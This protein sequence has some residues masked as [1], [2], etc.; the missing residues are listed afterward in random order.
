VELLREC[1][2][3]ILHTRLHHDYEKDARQCTL[4]KLLERTDAL[5]AQSKAASQDATRSNGKANTDPTCVDDPPVSAAPASG[6]GL[7]EAEPICWRR[8]W[9]GDVSD[10]GMFVH[11]DSRDDLDEQGPWESLYSGDDYNRLRVYALSLREQ[12]EGMVELATK[13]LSYADRLS[14]RNDKPGEI[15]TML[16]EAATALSLRERRET[17]LTYP[18]EAASWVAIK[19]DKP[20]A[21]VEKAAYDDLRAIHIALREQREGMMPNEEDRRGGWKISPK[22]LRAVKSRMVEYPDTDWEVIEDVL[23][24]ATPSAGREER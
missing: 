1:R 21:V 20:V 8:E 5:L 2:K 17:L 24:A 6:E 16:R 13:L 11:A 10:I 12:R 7:P 19:G 15:E 3:E 9:D 23:L 14:H 4:C 18:S 22:Y